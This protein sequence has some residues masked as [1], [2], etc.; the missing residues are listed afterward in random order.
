ML[1]DDFDIAV[2]QMARV[3]DTEIRISLIEAHGPPACNWS[4]GWQGANSETDPFRSVSV[5][6]KVAC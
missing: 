2:G 4:P 3:K 6:K 1:S 5:F